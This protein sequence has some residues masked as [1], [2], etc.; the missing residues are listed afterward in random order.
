MSRWLTIKPGKGMA[1][2]W[3]CVTA[4]SCP[5]R[6]VPAAATPKQSLPVTCYPRAPTCYLI[7]RC[8]KKGYLLPRRVNPATSK[9]R[10]LNVSGPHP[11]VTNSA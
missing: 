10:N 6:L 5:S 9:A 1:R 7:M 3:G 2:D 4:L 8:L 11:C